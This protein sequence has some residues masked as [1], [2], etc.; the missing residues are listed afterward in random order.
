MS[1]LR[2]LVQHCQPDE[3]ERTTLV[4]EVTT[5]K[6]ESIEAEEGE[7][8]ATMA[9]VAGAMVAEVEVVVELVL[10]PVTT[11]MRNGAL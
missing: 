3:A 5:T 9:M 8:V 11:L 2:R 10:I 1:Q 4:G 7:E 6:R